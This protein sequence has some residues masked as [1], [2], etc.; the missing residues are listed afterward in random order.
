MTTDTITEPAVLQWGEV[1]F[2][3]KDGVPLDEVWGY[4][5]KAS[6][7]AGSEGEP[8]YYWV[9]PEWLD[10]TYSLGRVTIEGRAYSS[11]Y[12]AQNIETLAEAKAI[13]ERDNR[14]RMQGMTRRH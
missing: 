2:I 7:T 10:D 11:D 12:F 4:E 3:S 6:W 5:A 1:S 9:H 13:A 14:E 8:G